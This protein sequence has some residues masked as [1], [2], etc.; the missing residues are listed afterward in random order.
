MMI[1]KNIIS[2]FILFFVS[3]FTWAQK[4]NYD[5]LAKEKEKIVLLFLDLKETDAIAD[6]GTN[7]GYSLIPIANEYPNIKFT[8]EDIDSSSCNI[9][10]ITKR[11][12]KLGYKTNIEQF[13]F[14]YGTETSTNLPTCKFNKVLMFMVLHEM[15]FKKE[16]LEDV[17]RILQK[18]GSIFIQENISHKPQKKQR[19]CNYRFLTEEEFKQVMTENKFLLKREQI[20]F[21]T[22]H[23]TY[24]KL[25]EYT[26]AD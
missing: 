20:S 1:Y 9:K 13:S 16:M 26:V 23:N 24:L 15:T 8:I 12:K 3:E 22:G 17:K 14:V 6:I 25:F 18:N 4:P 19:A 10:N 5:S 2:L 7:S 11:I 21:D